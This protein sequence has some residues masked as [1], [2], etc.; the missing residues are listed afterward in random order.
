MAQIVYEPSIRHWLM[1]YNRN[2]NLSLSLYL[3]DGFVA[4]NDSTTHHRRTL[5][6]IH[7]HPTT[8]P[9][10]NSISTAS[11]P[12]KTIINR[13]LSIATNQWAC[14]LLAWSPSTER[15][16]LHHFSKNQAFRLSS[17]SLSSTHLHWST[18]LSV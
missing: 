5:S 4:D 6:S 7:H 10:N 8:Y 3:L 16:E 15:I 1:K 9:T 12:C 13:K 14:H 11:H 17:P 18:T 2:T